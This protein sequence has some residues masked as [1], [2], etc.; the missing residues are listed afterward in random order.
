[1]AEVK[2]SNA[3]EF[4]G[5][6]TLYLIDIPQPDGKTTKTVR[7]FNQTSGSR[8]IEA[9]EIELK[10][11]DKSGS[12]Y[13]DVTQS[14]SIEGI[15]TE[16]DEGLD[17]VEEAILNKVLVRIHEVNLRSA[18]ASEFKVKSGTYMLNSLELSHEN[19]EYSKYSIG[20]K[21]NGKISKGTLNKVPNGAPTGDVATPGA[22]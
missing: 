14:A 7:F 20:L 11:K 12:D 13:G 9:G 10:T 15:C 3:P 4:K 19:E 8:S 18:T 2:K 6:E 16:G 5:A 22:E 17:Y 1:M 21:L